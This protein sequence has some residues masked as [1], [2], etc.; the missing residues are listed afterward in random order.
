MSQRS[1]VSLRSSRR[2]KAPAP[3]NGANRIAFVSNN[4][5][6]LVLFRSGII[7]K[8]VRAG[9]EVHVIAPTDG[10]T[11]SLIALGARFHDLRLST[12]GRNPIYE[13]RAVGQLMRLY[14]RVAPDLIFHFTLK[15]NL[16]GVFAAKRLSIPCIGVVPGLGTF[17]DVHN[18]LLRSALARG[19]AY[20]A[21]H[22]E[23][24]WFLNQHDY[25]FFD[26]RRWLANTC[27]RVLPGEGVNV[28]KFDYRP[29]PN[30]SRPRILF[31][32]RLLAAKGVEVFA[33][34]ATNAHRFGLP[35][36]FEMLGYLEEN[37]PTGIS[38]ERLQS[39]V[40]SGL[41]TYH[42]TAAD[43]RPYMTAADVIVLPT[44]YREGLNRVLQEAM[45][46]GRPVVTT[47]VPGAGEL[48]EHEATGYVVP[49]RDPNA[50]LE[51]LSYHFSLTRTQRSAMGKRARDHI[52]RNYDEDIVHGHYFDVVARLAKRVRN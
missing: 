7:A 22:A 39:W 41:L 9:Y 17:P 19:Y 5:A 40:Q 48:V 8:L 44:Y 30:N 24:F 31:V 50:V 15:L 1:G 52:V 51:A 21:R 18:P 29:L 2:R 42:G 20:A 11:S 16:Y 28:K 47:N 46:I 43:V 45:A 49:A 4:G 34:A 14:R 3:T 32:G 36:D 38:A 13:A 26:A 25:G 12:Q 37:S 6:G 27:A 33:E 35:Y 10:N 23:E